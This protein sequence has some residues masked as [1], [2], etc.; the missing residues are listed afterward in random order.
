MKRIIIILIL[1]LVTFEILQGQEQQPEQLL[2]EAI[3]QEEVN[4]ELDE[5]ITSYQFIIKQYPANRKVAAEALLHLGLCYEKK[6]MQEAAA[7]QVSF[8]QT[9]I[10]DDM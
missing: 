6:G 7:Q 8:E 1:G 5:A 9:L 4:G 3:Y 10:C 2:S